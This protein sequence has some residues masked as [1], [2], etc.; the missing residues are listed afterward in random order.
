MSNLNSFFLDAETCVFNPLSPGDSDVGKKNHSKYMWDVSSSYNSCDLN[1][2]SQARQPCALLGSR[3]PSRTLKQIHHFYNV[4][5]RSQCTL[6][7]PGPILGW[8][9]SGAGLPKCFILLV[10]T[11][12]VHTCELQ[13]DS[14]RKH[15]MVKPQK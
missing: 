9:Y 8:A 7:L 5:F 15:M 6:P 1:K 10:T 12:I 3:L 14:W 4:S 13:F 2:K 11:L